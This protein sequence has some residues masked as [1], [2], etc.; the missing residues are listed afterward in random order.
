[1]ELTK[2]NSDIAQYGEKYNF[3]Y[4]T[5]NGTV[6]CT[7]TYKG[8]IVRGIAKCSPEDNFDVET[9]KRLAYLRCKYKFA[10]KKLKH[11]KKVYNEAVIANARAKNNFEK[12]RE[13]M[14]D[15]SIQ[16]ENINYE[17]TDFEMDLGIV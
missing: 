17:L 5:G 15:S 10:K 7:T 3:Y 2:T 6:V 13:F 9:G 8:H 4:N 16:L 1:M 11:A 14:C 12:A